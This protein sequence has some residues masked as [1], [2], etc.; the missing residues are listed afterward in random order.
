MDRLLRLFLEL[1]KGTSDMSIASEAARA[2]DKP[3]G[4]LERVHTAIAARILERNETPRLR[5]NFCNSNDR[6]QPVEGVQGFC[7]LRSDCRQALANRN[8]MATAHSGRQSD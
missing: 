2:S 7:Q 1:Q 3:T 4:R 5:K 6:P 8:M